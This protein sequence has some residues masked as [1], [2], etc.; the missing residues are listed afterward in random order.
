MKNKKWIFWI[1]AAVSAFLGLAYF[2][3]P[4]DFIPDV[5][6]FIGWLDDLIVNLL[7]LVAMSANVLLALGVLPL[8]KKEPEF[9]RDCG[10]Y[11]YYEER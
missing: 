10:D 7:T 8:R 6:A 2:V 5:I 3:F 9:A 11:G 1:I 4:A